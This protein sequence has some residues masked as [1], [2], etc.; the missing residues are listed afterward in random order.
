ML[1]V[2][3]V[4]VISAGNRVVRLVASWIRDRLG[5]TLPT[6]VSGWLSDLLTVL[7]VAGGETA[8]RTGMDELRV[9][10]WNSFHIAGTGFKRRW[11]VST[12]AADKA[13]FTLRAG[14]QPRILDSF[15]SLLIR[16]LRTAIRA[17]K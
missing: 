8:V 3:C 15:G 14:V 10:P 13:L 4:S 5:T 7:G 9:G 11:C 1:L 6:P 16:P 2:T 17:P 12:A